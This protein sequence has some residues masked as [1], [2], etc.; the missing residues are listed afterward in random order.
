M[1]GL[2]LFGNV[3]LSRES[4][5]EANKAYYRLGPL[6]LLNDNRTDRSLRR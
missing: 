5:S 1:N 2:L 4:S 3:I 6:S